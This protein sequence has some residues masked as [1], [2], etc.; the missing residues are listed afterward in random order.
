L[1]LVDT[2]RADRLGCYG[3]QRDTSPHLDAL[4]SEGILFTD[5]MT[6]GPS[7][8]TSV[9]VLLTGRRLGAE[10]MVRVR[11]D[12]L[13]SHASPGPDVPTLAELLEEHGYETAFISANALVNSDIGLDRGFDHFDLSCARR[14]GMD[15]SSAP[16]VNLSAYEWLQGRDNQRKPF[17]LYLQYMEPHFHYRPPAEFCVFGRPGYTARDTKR[18]RQVMDLVPHP[19]HGVLE[20]GERVTEEILSGQGLSRRDIERLSDLYDG[21]VLCVDHYLGQLFERL[22]VLGLYEDTLIIVTAD[23]GEGFLEHGVMG[24]GQAL[25][26]ELVHVPLIISG[27]GLLRGRLIHDLVELVDIAPTILEAAGIPLTIEMSG[28]SFYQALSGTAGIADDTGM[29][30]LP[31]RMRAFRSG[32]LKLIVS[33][34]GTELYDLSKDPRETTDLAP[35]RPGQ[36]DRLRAML[37]DLVQRQ[38]PPVVTSES[39][40]PRQLEALK[41]LGYLR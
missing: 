9:P 37:E 14:S 29:A 40:T 15:L 21:E 6:Q 41:A 38:P 7:T 12:Q 20:P 2:L 36:V 23:H 11:W 25:Y 10:G 28:R 39:P 33:R 22:R 30:E 1:I 32:P 19:P 27:P 26:Q 35:S 5:V 4:A 3:Y 31:G 24:H 18:N 34:E 16:D 13:R 17:F 8:I